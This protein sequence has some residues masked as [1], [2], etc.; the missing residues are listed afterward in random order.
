MTAAEDG[1]THLLGDAP[2]HHDGHVLA[3]ALPS[4]VRAQVRIHLSSHQSGY[5][6]ICDRH[7]SKIHDTRM[8]EERRNT[9]VDEAGDSGWGGRTDRERR[10]RRV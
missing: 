6:V 1:K 10:V 8:K 2:G 3:L 7:M 9:N 5:R 4:H